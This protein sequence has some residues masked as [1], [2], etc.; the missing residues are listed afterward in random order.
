MKRNRNPATAAALVLAALAVLAACASETKDAERQD[1]DFGRGDD[2]VAVENGEVR[3]P[4]SIVVWLNADHHPNV[5]RVCLDGLAFL[6]VS[7]GHQT[8]TASVQRIAE[9]D[10]ECAR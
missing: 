10:D 5:V 4:D 8:H 2:E 7:D 9:W 3:Q 6:T 1:L